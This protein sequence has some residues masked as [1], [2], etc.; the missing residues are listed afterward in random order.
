MKAPIGLFALALLGLVVWVVLAIISWQ[1]QRLRRGYW[2]VGLSAL[3][4]AGLGGALM[5]GGPE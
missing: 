4:A 3:L 2:W 1:E 5:Y